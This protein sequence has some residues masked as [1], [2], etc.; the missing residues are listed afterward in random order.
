MLNIKSFLS[1]LAAG[2]IGGVIGGLVVNFAS[3]PNQ[4]NNNGRAH[5]NPNNAMIRQ[6]EIMNNVNPAV[7][8][9]K[10]LFAEKCQDDVNKLCQGIVPGEGRIV[11]CLQLAFKDVS[12]GCREVIKKQ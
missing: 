5:F 7:S 9:N 1:L 11:R 4:L 10:D 8:A 6:N 2:F 3:G 12:T